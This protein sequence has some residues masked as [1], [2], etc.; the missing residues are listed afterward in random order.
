MD[1]SVH[2]VSRVVLLAACGVQGGPTT[3]T[4]SSAAESTSGVE[5]GPVTEA[6]GVDGVTSTGIDTGGEWP[7]CQPWD[8]DILDFAVGPNSWSDADP[9]EKW[10]AGHHFATCDFGSFSEK[11][12]ME[13][14][15]WWFSQLLSLTNCT[16]EQGM[17]TIYS[18]NL[19]LRSKA[20]LVVPLSPGQSVKVSFSVKQWQAF[21]Y[22]A[23]YSLRD[24]QTDELLLAMFADPGPSVQPKVPDEP[25]LAGWLAPFEA[26]LGDFVCPVEVGNYCEGD[27]TPQRAVV[28]FTAGGKAFDVVGGTFGNLGD[29]TVQLGFA[30][31]PDLCEL[32]PSHLPIQGLIVKSI[33]RPSISW[34]ADR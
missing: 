7:D 16:D 13:Q 9:A 12:V 8:V 2:V 27:D 3:G 33:L 21:D 4:E 20:P 1:R 14:G 31:A 11:E 10:P 29:Y 15:K 24:A 17:P 34:I 5:T 6:S 18:L 22:Q 26:V 28:H 25:P 23:W 30:G 32:L 19:A